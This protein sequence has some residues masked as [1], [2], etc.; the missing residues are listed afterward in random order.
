MV[1]KEKEIDYFYKIN[2]GDVVTIFVN[3]DDPE[4]AYMIQSSDSELDSLEWDMCKK[5]IPK[6]LMAVFAW[7]LWLY[8][9][10][11]LFI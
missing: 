10:Y 2:K 6:L 7:V 9:M 11:Q 8:G 4:D 5:S 3:P 1:E